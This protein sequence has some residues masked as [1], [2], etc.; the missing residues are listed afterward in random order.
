MTY[1]A[2]VRID[3]AAKSGGPVTLRA[4]DGTPHAGRWDFDLGA[5][6]YAPGMPIGKTITHYLARLPGEAPPEEG[7]A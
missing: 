5:F 1:L 2:F 6:A 7:D 3:K 4:D